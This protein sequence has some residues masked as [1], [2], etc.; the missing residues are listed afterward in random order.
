MYP[1]GTRNPLDGIYST[2]LSYWGGGGTARRIG[3]DSTGAGAGSTW[4]TFFVINNRMSKPFSSSNLQ[5]MIQCP[6]PEGCFSDSIPAGA[7]GAPAVETLPSGILL[8]APDDEADKLVFR[9]AISA[10]PRNPLERGTE[11]PVVRERDFRTGFISLPYIELRGPVRV[12]LRLYDPDQHVNAQVRV[13]LRHWNQPAVTPL[14][15]TVVTLQPPP[16]FF[17]VL[18]APVI[19]PSYAE[20]DLQA[21]FADVIPQGTYFNVDVEPLTPGLRFWAFA[22]ITDNV[23]NDVQTVTPH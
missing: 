11:I 9:L 7:F 23:T 12:R 5:F 2:R 20:M 3:S 1:P 10:R 15:S 8:F 16:G 6:I 14:A 19:R 13:T 17:P 21:V 22:T 4:Q 18:P